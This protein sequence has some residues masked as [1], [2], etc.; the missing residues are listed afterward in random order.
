MRQ[1]IDNRDYEQK[2][3]KIVPVSFYQNYEEN[4]PKNKLE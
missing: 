4:N 1:K 3:S 2:F